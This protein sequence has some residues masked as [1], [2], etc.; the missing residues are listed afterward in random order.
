MITEEQR[1]Q[2]KILVV[3]DQV[4]NIQLLEYLLGA[5]GYANVATLRDSQRVIAMHRENRYDLII[6]D[7][8][9]PGMTGFEVMEALRELEPDD[10]PVL[11]VTAD[12]D[13]K[14]QAMDAGARDFVGKP[15]DPPEVLARIRAMLETRLSGPRHPRQRGDPD[16]ATEV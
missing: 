16:W 9:M 5:S 7:L 14:M 3:D 1:L 4:V 2:A 15:F 12:P 11:V 10:L 6:L 13:K 8:N